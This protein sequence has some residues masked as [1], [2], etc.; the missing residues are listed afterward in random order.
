MSHSLANLEDHH[1]K[2]PQFRVPGD[3]HLYFF[4]TMKLSF[5]Q[6]GPFQDGDR[7]EIAFEGMGAPLAN[8]V[9]KLPKDDRPIVVRKG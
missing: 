3:V 1:F 9:R 4:G 5:G 6:R 2:H 8:P 7:V